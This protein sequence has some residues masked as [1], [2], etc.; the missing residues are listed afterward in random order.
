[1]GWSPIRM[2]PLAWRRDRQIMLLIA[3]LAGALLGAAAGYLCFA[4]GFGFTAE[5]FDAWL[6][7]EAGDFVLIW[8]LLGAGTGAAIVW[9]TQIGPRDAADRPAAGA[10]AEI[11]GAE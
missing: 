6:G 11:P 4:I 2:N 8:A 3:V 9:G 7:G 10:P 1:M 5:T